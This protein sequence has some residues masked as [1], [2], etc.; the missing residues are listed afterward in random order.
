VDAVGTAQA[1][2]PWADEALRAEQREF[3]RNSH[4]T[5][6]DRVVTGYGGVT[7]FVDSDGTVYECDPAPAP[8]RLERDRVRA[9]H[10]RTRVRNQRLLQAERRIVAGA[11]FG[12]RRRLPQARRPRPAARRRTADATRGSPSDDPHLGDDNPPGSRGGSGRLASSADV[13]RWL[14]DRRRV[15]A[16]LAGGPA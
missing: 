3:E 12:Q 7:S 2:S 16:A 11:C 6:D 10:K 1:E 4:V 9:D 13:E 5:S 14:A 8:D 15:L